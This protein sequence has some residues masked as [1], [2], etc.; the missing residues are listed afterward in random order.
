MLGTTLLAENGIR[1]PLYLTTLRQLGQDIDQ[2][3]HMGR[4][5]DIELTGIEWTNSEATFT[6]TGEAGELLKL[7]QISFA[8]Q[9]NHRS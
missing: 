7:E 8:Y 9:E 4:L 6:K 3:E 2:L 1:E 5:E